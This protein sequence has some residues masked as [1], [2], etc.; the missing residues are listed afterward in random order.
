MGFGFWSVCSSQQRGLA[1]GS[2]QGKV[3]LGFQPTVGSPMAFL[4]FLQQPHDTIS[5]A[6]AQFDPMGCVGH[7]AGPVRV[8]FWV[9]PIQMSESV[10]Y[11]VSSLPFC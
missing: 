5:S 8:T 9:P 6:P 3:M 2:A 10:T 11:E 1:Q 7:Q 4:L